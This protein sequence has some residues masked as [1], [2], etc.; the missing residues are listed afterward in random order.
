MTTHLLSD[1]RDA[2]AADAAQA[3]CV[4][5]FRHGLLLAIAFCAGLAI[6]AGS[7]RVPADPTVPRGWGGQ[8]Q[9]ESLSAG[10]LRLATFN[11]HSGKG[12]DG[13]TDLDR[14]ADELAGFDVVGLNEVRGGFG[15]DAHQAAQLGRRLGMAWL[16][17]PTERR[18]WHE[19]FGNGILSNIAARSGLTIP[20]PGTQSAKHR[21]AVLLRLGEGE[22]AISLLVT[23]LD[24]VSDRQLQLRA[25]TE[26]FLSLEP[27]AVLIGDLNTPGDDPLLKA[28]LSRPDVRDAVADVAGPRARKRRI[29]WII[30]RGLRVRDA[31]IRETAASDHPL[32]WAEL[33][34]VDAKSGP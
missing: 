33:E 30:T 24:H 8:P 25:V 10:R 11:I 17:A 15:P 31:G 18:W 14:I 2:S 12:T 9:L 5:G 19:H 7:D 16:F 26:L 34:F 29:D 3:A 4:R 21:N 27:P 28:L 6:W 1:P 20:L 32:V 13:Q 23:H 22:R